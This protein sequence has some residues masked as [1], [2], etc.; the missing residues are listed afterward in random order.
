[1][2]A[3]PLPHHALSSYN[4]GA[5]TDSTN[6]T[7]YDQTNRARSFTASAVLLLIC[8]GAMLLSGCGLQSGSDTIAF[9]QGKSLWVINPD[10]SSPRRVA[11]GN[12]VS[13][14]WSPDHHQYVMRVA[15]PFNSPASLSPLGP[16]DAPGD[17]YVGSVNGGSPIQIT[18]G[19][20]GL[21][22]SDAW[23]N[24][25]GNRLLYR[26]SFTGA[27]PA[28][29]T[30]IVSQAD[31]PVGIARKPI[32]VNFGIP[33]VSPDGSQIATTDSAGNVR[34]GAPNAI[35]KIVA[36]GAVLTLP[37]SNRPSRLLW[38]PH[39][40]ALLYI[41]SGANVSSSLELVTL[42]GA[43]RTLGQVTDLLDL[44]FSPDGSRMLLRTKQQF[45][46]WSVAHPGQAAYS[47]DEA[48]PAALP[49]WSPAGGRILVQESVRWRLVDIAAR[50][51]TTLI[52]FPGA[53]L[54][55]IS[56][57]TGWHPAAGSPWNGAGD[58]FVFVAP[59]RARWL[60]KALSTSGNGAIGLYVANPSNSDAPKKIENGPGRAPTWSYLDPSTAF[61]VMA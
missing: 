51:V 56:D 25:N 34:V 33:V 26:E 23:W 44:A 40:D 61:L 1:M 20:A 55:N 6:A 49:W 45:T 41:A 7:T 3:V 2:M 37:G 54:A 48:D 31:Q 50:R 39:H 38:Q 9:L 12:I 30:Y 5:M 17:L 36:T 11:Q 16:P 52:S 32:P 53:S 22:R 13:V 58:R 29:A 59:S 46:I 27:G 47:W 21:S 60:G 57:I 15:Q 43:K 10:G 4:S 42:S 24:P 14:A 8:L 28:A 35:G 18:P 19:L